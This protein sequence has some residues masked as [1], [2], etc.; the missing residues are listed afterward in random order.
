[1]EEA[2]AALIL[3]DPDLASKASL[4]GCGDSWRSEPGRVTAWRGAASLPPR[5]RLAQLVWAYARAGAL[6]EA[7]GAPSPAALAAALEASAQAAAERLGLPGPLG[8]LERL[9][10]AVAVPGWR[11]MGA[12]EVARR[13]WEASRSLGPRGLAARL[14]L[15][16]ASP[17]VST[18]LA[19][20]GAGRPLSV[21]EAPPPGGR[22]SGLAARALAALRA[23][24]RPRQGRGW[25]RPP[26]RLAGAG[27]DVVYP[28]YS[29]RAPQSLAVFLDVSGSMEGGKG[30]EARR[31]AEAIITGFPARRVALVAFDDGVR[32]VAWNPGS[33]RGLPL[34]PAGGTRVSRALGSFKPCSWDA[35]A[36]ISD[37]GLDEEDLAGA[38]EWLNE[39]VRRGCSAL[40]VSVS[41][42]TE[43]PRGPW[44]RVYP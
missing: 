24:A 23:S 33:L 1:V 21:G 13:L 44:A 16:L 22:G 19:S 2:L 15:A 38:V 39:H 7:R 34:E 10:L 3:L 30:E 29:H 41:R 31:V 11:G 5:L 9:L 25:L 37:W 26:K 27:G 28:G 8:A 43:P 40:L 32:L 6:R 14:L 20:A 42:F 4:A 18:D 36:V 12:G 35:L 17:K